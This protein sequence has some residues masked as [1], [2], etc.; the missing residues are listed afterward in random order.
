MVLLC[1]GLEVGKSQA[2]VI[3]DLG[4]GVVASSKTI[5]VC[6]RSSKIACLVVGWIDPRPGDRI[7]GRPALDSIDPAPWGRD[8]AVGSPWEARAVTGIGARMTLGRLH[9]ASRAS[10]GQTQRSWLMASRTRAWIPPPS[11]ERQS[12]SS[13]RPRRLLRWRASRS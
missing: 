8:R 7:Q 9:R 2:W 3:R 6:A 13:A 10:C 4:R 1:V 5:R 12:T 11:G